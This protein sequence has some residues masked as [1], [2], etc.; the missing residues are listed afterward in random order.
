[1]H[2]EKR[3]GYFGLV[4]DGQGLD[5]CPM[6]LLLMFLRDCFALPRRWRRKSATAMLQ[7]TKQTQETEETYTVKTRQTFDSARCNL[8]SQ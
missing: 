8:E 2:T 1:M 6:S 7:E 3:L 5:A 4:A